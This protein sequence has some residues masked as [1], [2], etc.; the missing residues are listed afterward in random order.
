AQHHSGHPDVHL[1][2]AVRNH[3]LLVH[4]E[5]ILERACRC[6]GRLD[7]KPKS[8]LD[9]YALMTDLGLIVMSGRK[10]VCHQFRGLNAGFQVLK[11]GFPVV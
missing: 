7:V 11:R 9:Y 10:I 3:G 8:S 5:D 6:T 2:S 4:D 1:V